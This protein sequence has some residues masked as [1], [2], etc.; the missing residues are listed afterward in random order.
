MAENFYDAEQKL[1]NFLATDQLKQERLCLAILF[2]DKRYS[3]VT[4]RQ[5]Y[6]GADYGRDIQVLYDD[7]YICFVGIG[8]KQD[9]NDS[10]EQITEIKRKFSNDLDSVLKN[11]AKEN[12]DLKGFVFFTNLRLTVDTRDSLIA[13][14]KK[15]GLLHCEIY[16]R[17]NMVQILNSPEG[18]AI[19]FE[20]LNIPLSE[21]E[22]KTFFSK[23][24][25]DIQSIIS[26]GF[27]IQKRAIDRMIFLQEAKLPI[28][29][30]SFV[31]N[32]NKKYKAEEIEHLRIICNVIFP[33][34]TK[35]QIDAH[36]YVNGFSIFFGDNAERFKEHDS[37]SKDLK[38]IK[39]GNSSALVLNTIN[40]ETGDL[41]YQVRNKSS[42]IGIEETDKNGNFRARNMHECIYSLLLSRR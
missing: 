4:S 10:K 39:F 11:A 7:I 36:L 25:K 31:I 23:W 12:I 40:D 2:L 9:A 5:P 29:Y 30:G 34:L 24:G 17:E 26:S 20:F 21:A 41:K 27:D 3:K 35:Y 15:Q 32:F 16:H 42:G 1:K 38:G 6:G 14:A 28:S 13:D 19:R 22:Q 8:F 33:D 18:F 37:S